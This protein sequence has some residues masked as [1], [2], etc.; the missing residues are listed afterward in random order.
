MAALPNDPPSRLIVRHLTAT[1]AYRAAKVLRDAPAD[2]A[3]ASFGS[4]T[5]H[6]VQIVRDQ[7]AQSSDGRSGSP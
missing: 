5:R 7:M 4:T 3:N 6:P 2:F 1:L